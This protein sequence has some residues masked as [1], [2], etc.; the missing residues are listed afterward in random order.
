MGR[1]KGR[2]NK[3]LIETL[4]IACICFY[5]EKVLWLREG[6][7][8]GLISRF[9]PFP[10]QLDH[11]EEGLDNINNEMKVTLASNGNDN[12]FAYNHF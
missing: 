5:W 9:F 4:E 12:D 6:C 7:W 1:G 10:E 8:I 11:I 2:W 3:G